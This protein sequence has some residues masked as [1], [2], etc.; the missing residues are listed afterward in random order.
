MSQ[1]NIPNTPVLPPSLLRQ[2]GDKPY[3]YSAKSI[4]AYYRLKFALEL[5]PF[6]DRII[7]DPTILPIKF[8]SAVLHIQ[9]DTLVLKLRLGWM[10]L[11][12]YEDP[13]KRYSKLYQQTSLLKRPD[14]VNIVPLVS[15]VPLSA[16]PADKSDDELGITDYIKKERLREE[17]G[18]DGDLTLADAQENPD[19]VKPWK[20]R[21]EEFVTTAPEDTILDIKRLKLSDEDV[22]WLEVFL[23]PFVETVAIIAITLKQVKLVKSKEMALQLRKDRGL[24]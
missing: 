24:V 20:L 13:D 22:Q 18:E 11:M 9:P 4:T 16:E 17:R 6:L 23:T 12:D 15:Q 1:D 5:R 10:Y 19:K 8:K 7:A 2:P 21:V 14:G 3:G